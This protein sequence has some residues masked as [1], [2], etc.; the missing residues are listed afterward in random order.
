M[1]QSG[2]TFDR[3]SLELDK[4]AIEFFENPN[5]EIDSVLDYK[6]AQPDWVACMSDFINPLLSDLHARDMIYRECKKR[7]T[8]LFS[9]RNALMQDSN[10]TNSLC[11]VLA[12]A[13]FWLGD[14]SGSLG[15]LNQL[16][17]SLCSSDSKLKKIIQIVEFLFINEKQR[18]NDLEDE[19][20][21]ENGSEVFHISPPPSLSKMTGNFS[22]IDIESVDV[23]YIQNEWEMCKSE[24]GE[25]LATEIFS[26]YACVTTNELENVFEVD[27]STWHRLVRKGFFENSIVGISENS[28]IKSK[29]RIIKV[30]NNTNKCVDEVGKI[31]SKYE[32]YDERFICALH[33]YL[34][35]GENFD[36]AEDD[37]GLEMCIMVIPAGAILYVLISY[38]DEL[39]LLSFR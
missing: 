13:L 17:W 34:M 20:T 2:K 23:R 24:V 31:F 33:S 25:K 3:E 35:E 27:G 15:F 9:K 30:L 38:F 5:F 18:E 26:R 28:K 21:D 32:S 19:T 10:L 37:E 11:I 7:Y 36:V 22:N 16:N 1:I 29:S 8:L 39:T 14:L 12:E 6:S 4:E